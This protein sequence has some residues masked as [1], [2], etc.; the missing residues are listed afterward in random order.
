MILKKGFYLIKIRLVAE[1]VIKCQ[2]IPN[3]T[4]EVIDRKVNSSIFLIKKLIPNGEKQKR[5][6]QAFRNNR[7]APVS[8]DVTIRELDVKH[9]MYEKDRFDVRN[10]PGSLHVPLDRY[11][12]RRERILKYKKE[13]EREPD[14]WLGPLTREWEL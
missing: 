6:L 4:M 8:W 14:Q 13:N 10:I 3:D 2:A 12:H 1:A 5:E 9:L 11:Y 7:M